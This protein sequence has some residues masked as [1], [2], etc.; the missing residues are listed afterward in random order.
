MNDKRAPSLLADVSND[1]NFA[2][3]GSWDQ[4]PLCG[5]AL[6]VPVIMRLLLMFSSYPSI[7]AT[8]KHLPGIENVTIA[9]PAPSNPIII[10]VQ[11][12]E[13]FKIMNDAGVINK[14]PTIIKTC[15][16]IDI[17]VG[18]GILSEIWKILKQA[19]F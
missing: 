14:L 3:H 11:T 18:Q 10:F 1:L 12:M 9:Y 16:K 8:L 17:N 4:N 15:P 7:F 19:S 2:A 13:G 6:R 5:A